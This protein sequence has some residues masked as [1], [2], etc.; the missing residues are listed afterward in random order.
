M[1]K[2]GNICA[3]REKTAQEELS[4]RNGWKVALGDRHVR[5]TASPFR[6]KFGSPTELFPFNN[7]Y[8]VDGI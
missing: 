6:A 1:A 3:S 4:R 8:L 5:H 2:Q 7:P